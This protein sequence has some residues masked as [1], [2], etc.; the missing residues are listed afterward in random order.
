[1]TWHLDDLRRPDL[2]GA[3]VRPD[4]TPWRRRLGTVLLADVAPV[5]AGLA[6]LLL[7]TWAIDRHAGQQT[8]LRA[9]ETARYL[10]RFDAPPVRD[11]WQRLHDAWQRES[12]RQEVLLGRLAGL[13][14]GDYRSVLH[15]Y[16]Q[17]VLETVEEHGLAPQVR[18]VFGFFRQLAV[19]VRVG[20][21]DRD[22]VARRLGG[23]VWQFRNQHYYYFEAEASVLELDRQAEV[24]APRDS[25]GSRALALP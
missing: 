3:V 20:N 1:M 8:E 6:L 4:L 19:C 25:G 23:P 13:A 17:F 12:P 24:I 5:A 18:T 9:A 2:L 15:D 14:G 21:C 7:G 10:A 16:Q 11:A 22:V